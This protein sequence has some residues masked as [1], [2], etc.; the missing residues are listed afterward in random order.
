[1]S[2]S[3]MSTGD[4]SANENQEQNTDLT[5]YTGRWVAMVGNE[6]VGV[7]DSA[8]S[9]ERFGR[10][11][12]VRD[13]LTVHY[14]EPPGG[15]ALSLPALLHELKPIF[16]RIDRPVYL[17]GGAV[18]DML[19]GRASKDLDFVVPHGAIGLTFK[20]ADHL[21]LP[22]YVLDRQRDAGRIVIQQQETTLD[23]TR[24]RGDDL[25][26]DLRDRD[27]CINALALPVGAWS[28]ASLID[29]CGGMGDL[30]KRLIRQTHDASIASDPVR[31]LR[32]IRLAL[33]LDFSLTPDTVA[34]IQK[35]GP[36]LPNVSIERVRDELLKMLQLPK[37]GEALNY[38]S[39]LDLLPEIL[40]SI[41]VLKEIEQ[42]LPHYESVLAHTRSTLRWIVSIE[43]VVV[44]YDLDDQAELA[45]RHALDI[46]L[47]QARE[48][49]AGYAPQLSQY[50]HRDVDG[51]LNG[52]LL[53]RLGALFHDVGKANTQEIAPDGRI[54]FYGHDKVGAN[55]TGQELVRLRLS[56]EAVRHVKKIVAGHMR[57]FYLA[58]DRA[59]SR[60]AIY[61]FF[62]DTGTAGLDICLLAL[63]DHLATKEGEAD[64]HEWPLLLDVI[65]KLLDHYFTKYS[66]TIKPVPLVDGRELIEALQFE[67]GPEI[68][69][70]LRLI[71]EAQAAGEITTREEAI[72]LAR[73]AR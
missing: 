63:A 12:R 38:L 57:P 8:V 30:E 64:D 54:R 6:V 66:A 31:A 70:L 39:D 43:E 23:F 71:E 28:Q 68:G 34:A 67:P 58:N 13:S 19:L 44:R 17:V 26:S 37:V 41:A 49:L 27:F 22:A 10:R 14:I 46:R 5:P 36:F 72:A 62:R 73:Q 21:G 9:A 48:R 51:G 69:R 18:R 25:E 53:L 1:M 45:E 55:I 40:P 16:I 42:S 11:N 33:D 3:E 32:A 29:P 56:K 20:V 52:R 50:L 7:G 24:Y 35:A 60:R 47:T 2:Q 4:R 65:E 15:K 59:I 61:R